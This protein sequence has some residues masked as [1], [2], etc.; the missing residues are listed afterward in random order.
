MYFLY[1]LGLTYSLRNSIV[2]FIAVLFIYAQNPA[3]VPIYLF[4]VKLFSRGLGGVCASV[5]VC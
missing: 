2:S 3:R 4:L 1:L 5:G